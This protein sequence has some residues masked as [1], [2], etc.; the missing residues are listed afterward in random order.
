[1][2]FL[3]SSLIVLLVTSV[4]NDC[5]AQQTLNATLIAE[6]RSMEAS[7]CAD[8]K[9]KGAAWAFHAYAAPDAVIKRDNDSLIKGPEAIRNYY[10]SEVYKQA[11][12]EWKPDFVDV[13][14]DG[15]LAYTYGK[16][17]WTMKDK[18]GNKVQFSGVFHTVWKKQ[19]D[20]SWKYVWD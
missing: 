15:T 10:S 17:T 14:A 20:G 3:K 8:L 4:I 1:M 18:T 9:A 16:Y 7:F 13:S 12:A 2:N 5:T 11:V 19:P 6:I